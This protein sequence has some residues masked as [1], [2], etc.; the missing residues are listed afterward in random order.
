MNIPTPSISP[1]ESTDT[2][3]REYVRDSAAF[4]LCCEYKDDEGNKYTLCQDQDGGE[5]IEE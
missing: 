1:I 3:I 4:V 2:F 5:W